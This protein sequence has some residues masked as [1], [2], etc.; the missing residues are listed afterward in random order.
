V[1]ACAK[2]KQDL[3]IL[4]FSLLFLQAPQTVRI[5]HIQSLLL[6]ESCNVLTL[7]PSKPPGK[8]KPEF[9]ELK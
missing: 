5:L 8:D 2:V 7:P 1:N 9:D 6:E 3:P 4:V